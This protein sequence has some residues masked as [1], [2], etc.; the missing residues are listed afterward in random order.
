M[1]QKYKDYPEVV[2]EVM[3]APPEIHSYPGSRRKP[4]IYSYYSI[5]LLL[6][7]YSIPDITL[8]NPAIN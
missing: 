3:I 4:L 6:L 2:T 5:S 1:V 7:L 8:N